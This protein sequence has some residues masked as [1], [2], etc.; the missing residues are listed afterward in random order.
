MEDTVSPFSNQS[1][2]VVEVEIK[3]KIK[4]TDYNYV[5]PSDSLK[6]IRQRLGILRRFNTRELKLKYWEKLLVTGKDAP[7]SFIEIV[8]DAREIDFRTHDF[9]SK[10]ENHWIFKK[11][12]ACEHHRI[13]MLPDNID[14]I[15]LIR[16]LNEILIKNDI[17][18]NIG[19]H[20]FLLTN[21]LYSM[22]NL[23]WLSMNNSGVT[24]NKIV[25]LVQAINRGQ[26][27]NLK[28][29]VLTNN[30]GITM[31]DLK[32]ELKKIQKG[33]LQYLETDLEEEE[34]EKEGN[35]EKEGSIL[36]K[37]EIDVN[38]QFKFMND[39][40]K[41]MYL[42]G[43]GIIKD[44][45]EE[46]KR[47]IIDYGIVT[48][49]WNERVRLGLADSFKGN[50][51]KVKLMKVEAALKERALGEKISVS[52]IRSEINSTQLIPKIKRVKR[53]TTDYYNIYK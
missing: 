31:K 48:E 39:A 25:S 46:T 17:V 20:N 37:L 1:D 42:I 6:D 32:N 26:L 18:F 3:S 38:D 2:N 27:K 11:L 50:S 49:G 36:E 7:G 44:D 30:K 8:K 14:M 16:D 29:I 40:K 24:M 43:K 23:V 12:R 45:L 53:I 15:E 9:E 10:N 4:Y 35:D 41:L 33:K 22:Q 28:A 34:K 51:Y 47:I 52:T 19:K 5:M 21:V 13:E